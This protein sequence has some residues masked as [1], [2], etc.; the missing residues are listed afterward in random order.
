MLQFLLDSK[1]PTIVFTRFFFQAAHMLFETFTS[2][3][4]TIATSE[5]ITW[6]KFRGEQFKHILPHILKGNLKGGP[7]YLLQQT[8]KQKLKEESQSY[9]TLSWHLNTPMMD[10]KVWYASHVFHLISTDTLKLR[11]C[12]SIL[13]KVLLLYNTGLFLSLL[14]SHF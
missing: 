4:T 9:F 2:Y 8:S 12:T 6:A 14:D 11:L 7:C 3:S 13:F 1:C 5:S 10:I